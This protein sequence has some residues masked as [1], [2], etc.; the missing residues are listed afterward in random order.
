MHGRALFGSKDSLGKGE[1]LVPWQQKNLGFRNDELQENWP[2]TASGRGLWELV[3]IVCAHVLP[4]GV[5]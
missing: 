1:G 4:A 5:W 3:G 2:T